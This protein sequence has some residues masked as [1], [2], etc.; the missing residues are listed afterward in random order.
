MKYVTRKGGA[1][2]TI[3]VP[4]DCGNNCPFC[5]NKKDYLHMENFSLDKIL[6]SVKTMDE[7]TPECDFV[8]SGGEPFSDL[9]GL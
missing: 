4:W 1:T 8:I 2:V 9:N 7:I 5:V 3:L 6:E